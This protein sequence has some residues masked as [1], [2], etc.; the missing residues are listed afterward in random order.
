M[1]GT[2]ERDDNPSKLSSFEAIAAKAQQIYE[3]N[4]KTEYE[5]KY[6]GHYVAVD[7]TSEKAFPH[8]TSA[9]ALQNARDA[10]PHGLFYVLRVGVKDAFKT[11]RK[12]NQS[13]HTGWF[14]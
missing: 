6:P 7:I 5:D 13:N 11:T 8:E 10:E 2:P 1:T 12:A 3:E 4:F 9:G 14:V